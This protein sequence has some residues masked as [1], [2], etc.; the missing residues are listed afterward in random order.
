MTKLPDH[1]TLIADGDEANYTRDGVTPDAWAFPVG[2][3]QYPPEM[4]YCATWHD[5]TGALNNGYRHSGIDL[6]LDVTPWGDIE[7]TLGLAIFNVAPGIV[8]YVTPNWYGVGMCVVRS[9][10]DGVPLW[11]RYAHLLHGVMSGQFVE[12][13]KMLGPFANWKTGDHLH[14][15]MALD[16]FTVEWL[17]AGIRWIDPVPILKAHLDDLRVDAMLAKG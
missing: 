6:N 12:A 1:L 5:P 2:E 14:F 17:T 7:R 16:K 3:G 15:D 11:I 10:H 9:E 4:W 8:Q 13:G